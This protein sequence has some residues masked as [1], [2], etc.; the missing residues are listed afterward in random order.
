MGTLAVQSPQV[1]TNL[2]ENR[3]PLFWGD[4]T[5]KTIITI[6]CAESYPQYWGFQTCS[7][8]VVLL[9]SRG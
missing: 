7:E 1:K 4:A 3:G 6:P 2:V 8:Q 5:V 9:V